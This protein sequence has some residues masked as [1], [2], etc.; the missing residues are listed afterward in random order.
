MVGRRIVGARVRVS[1][2][3]TCMLRLKASERQGAMRISRGSAGT[4]TVMV[5]PAPSVESTMMVP[6]LWETMP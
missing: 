5:V 1:Y 2:D 3:R 6:P 4:A